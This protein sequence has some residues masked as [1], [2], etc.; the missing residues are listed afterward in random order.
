MP[1]SLPQRGRGAIDAPPN[2]F[3]L[4]AVE[5]DG[6]LLDLEGPPR[7]PTRYFVDASR[8]LIAFNDSPDVGFDASINVYRGCEHGCA[9]CYARPSHEYLGLDAGLDFESMIFVKPD[10][11]RLLRAELSKPSWKPT[12]LAMSGVTDP[13]QPVERALRLTRGCLEVLSAFR[14]PVSVVT[15]GHAVT[16]D[17]DVLLELSR[18]GAAR[19]DVSV[20]TLDPHLSSIMEPRAASPARRLDAIRTLA[21]VGVPV[22]VNVAPVVPGL[23]DHE[24]PAIL[25]AAR[26]AGAAWAHMIVVRL[27][28]AV[29]PVF[30]R[31][32]RNHLPDRSEKVL[33][34]VMEMKGGR[35]ND[36]RFGH[37]FT[38]SGVFFEQLKQLFHVQRD[39]L[40]LARS[41]PELS[42]EHFRVPGRMMQGGLFD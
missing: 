3:E 6:E 26:E 30:V 38:G 1:L 37:R 39:R 7:V 9:Y 29:R 10:A 12:R 5:P 34:R 24:M 32:L 31:W 27:P 41:A 23:T 21:R 20:T 28:G 15:K 14:Q 2:R 18:F 13:Y 42:I 33:H 40:G 25:E 11:P 35:L 4:I 16:R 19:V 22:G 17:I 8:S 36:P